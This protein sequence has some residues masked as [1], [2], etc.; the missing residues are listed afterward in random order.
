ML[1]ARDDEGLI[2]AEVAAPEEGMDS[3]ATVAESQVCGFK[4]QV[5]PSDRQSEGQLGSWSGHCTQR[6]KRNEDGSMAIYV[7]VVMSVP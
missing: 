1:A 7:V 2:D 5:K 3:V 6:R 4:T